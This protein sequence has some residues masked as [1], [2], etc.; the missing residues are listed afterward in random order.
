MSGQ[1]FWCQPQGHDARSSLVVLSFSYPEDSSR[2]PVLWHLMLVCKGCA[3]S[4][5]ISAFWSSSDAASTETLGLG[6]MAEMILRSYLW[7]VGEDSHSVHTNRWD[8]TPL[9][10][11]CTSSHCY[12]PFQS[13]HNVYAPCAQP[14]EWLLQHKTKG[15]CSCQQLQVSFL[16]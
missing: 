10:G 5:S 13:H 1:S 15:D 7:V 3:L 16:V 12:C 9:L 4:I 8:V 14:V 2:G 6:I 11:N